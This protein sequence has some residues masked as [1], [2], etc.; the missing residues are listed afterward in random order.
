MSTIKSSSSN[1]KNIELNNNFL[2][3]DSGTA[4]FDEKAKKRKVVGFIKQKSFLGVAIEENLHL[5]L[6]Q[7]EIADQT[8]PQTPPTKARTA[9]KKISLLKLVTSKILKTIWKGGETFKQTKPSKATKE[10]AKQFTTAKK[11]KRTSKTS[12]VQ[13]TKQERNVLKSREVAYREQ[14]RKAKLTWKKRLLN[15]CVLLLCGMVTGVGLG[16]W[17][18]NTVLS[19]NVNWE[20]AIAE[21]PIYEQSALDTRQSALDKLASGATMNDLTLAENYQIALYNFENSQNYTLSA[22]GKIATIA[23]QT[24]F[25]E[26]KFDGNL[27]QSITISTGFMNIAERAQM[28]ANSNSVTTVKGNNITQTSATWNGAQNTYTLDQYKTLSGGLPSSCQNYIISDKTVLNNNDQITVIQQDNGEVYY[29]FTL[30]LDRMYSALNYIEQIK[31]T[32]SL[33]SYPEFESILQTIT[34]DSDWNFVSIDTEEHYSIVA[35]GMRNTC[36]GTLLSTFDF[37]SAVKI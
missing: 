12:Y 23:T 10:I 16:T 4:F 21:R 1:E 29:Q 6:E 19:S 32:S 37:E 35:Y 34:I 18:Y 8:A 7:E 14:Q 24:I 9:S 17:Y 5:P 13:L 3:A 27:Y 15:F 36:T 22:T 30:T 25:A 31:Y 26:K 20:D 11:R 28:Q 33:S 2:S